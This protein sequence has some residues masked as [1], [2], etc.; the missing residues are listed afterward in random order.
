MSR[1]TKMGFNYITLRNCLCLF[2][3]LGGGTGFIGN[4]LTSLLRGNGYNVTVISRMPAPQRITWLDLERNGL[5]KGLKTFYI[6][7]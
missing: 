6:I 2:T 5:P 3:I 4:R 1:A 7:L